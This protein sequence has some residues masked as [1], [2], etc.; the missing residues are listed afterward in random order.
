MF[1]CQTCG[2]YFGRIVDTPLSEKHLKN[3]DLFISLLSQ[4]V[5]CVEAG[6]RMGSLP[7]DV[8][9]RVTAWREWLLRLDP[10]GR[11]E[12]CVRLGGRPTELEPAPL[13]YA[14][15]GAREDLALTA[16]LTRKFDELNSTSRQPPP[17]PRCGSRKTHFS[18][19]SKGGIPG[20][21]CGTCRR[22]FSRRSGTPLVNTKTAALERMREFIRYLALPLSIMQV[23]EIVG[24]S[25]GMAQKWRDMFAAFAG[26]LEPCG[27]LTSKIRLGVTPDG[28]TPCPFCGR[29][30]TAQH[31]DGRGW[32]CSGCGRLFS[33][34]R[35][36]VDRNG[37]LH[38]VSD[39]T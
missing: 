22:K 24:T 10:G 39:E 1:E 9:R 35:E 13:D 5:S 3:L 11:W 34:R 15:I 20:F 2:R 31:T 6:E 23:S 26:Q 17:C 12:R 30:G 18:G 8:G 33:M 14:E 4:P 38:I 28:A 21:Q 7:A 25:A 37:R 27:S 19:E 32:S 36:V 16:R 29:T